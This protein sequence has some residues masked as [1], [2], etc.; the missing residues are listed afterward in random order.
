MQIHELNTFNG[1][2]DNAYFVVDNGND[3]GKITRD[4]ILSDV[5]EDISLL[6]TRID[7]LISGLTIDS[8]VIDARVGANGEVYGSLGT[9]IRTQVSDITSELGATIGLQ[10]TDY[11][12]FTPDGD[13]H[14]YATKRQFYSVIAPAGS[15]INAVKIPIKGIGGGAILNA[16]LWEL[17]PDGDT[18]TRVNVVNHT[19]VANSLNEIPV[20]YLVRKP[21]YVALY[22]YNCQLFNV[23]AAGKSFLYDSVN[24]ADAASLSLSNLSTTPSQLFTGGFDYSVL[25]TIF[26]KPYRLPVKWRQGIVNSSGHIY[27]SP[28]GCIND[29]IIPTTFC[30]YIEPLD[31]SYNV[32]IIYFNESHGK[33]VFATRTTDLNAVTRINKS[34]PYFTVHIFKSW[35]D[36]IPVALCD[37][38]VALYA[39]I[40][41]IPD[42]L[43]EKL[44]NNKPVLNKTNIWSICH[45]GYDDDDLG[46]NKRGGYA[47]AALRGFTHGEVDI[48]LTSDHEVVCCHDD[49]FVDATSGVTITIASKTLAEL[50]TC[51]YYGTTIAT[52]GE[53]IEECK[54]YGLGLLIDQI[55]TENVNF[56]CDVVSKY[57][58]WDICVMVSN[59][60][61]EYPDLAPSLVEYIR[62]NYCD[63]AMVSI[64]CNDFASYTG[65]LNY[66]MSIDN[67]I[68]AI[69]QYADNKL[70]TIQ[71]IAAAL[72][73]KCRFVIWTVDELNPALLNALPY[74]NGF[75]S[76]AWSGNDIFNPTINN[77]VR[78]Y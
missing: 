70:S 48:K 38:I 21:C 31:T 12:V 4:A 59:Y 73:G 61:N 28:Y 7:N 51:D 1:D 58:A 63:S 60:H 50:Q 17:E 57:N 76:N 22:F 53:I 52:L 11:T 5:E 67:A 44:Y 39:N 35:N 45:Q 43:F 75:T 47:I 14:Y 34:Y 26:D 32:L 40:T 55:S 36:P 30:D 74:I 78:A 10:A 3:T 37:S 27:T 69:G 62:T 18:L 16:E 24:N 33:P 72:N 23:P 2:L 56:A 15:W 25:S 9:A 6:D 66:A 64:V 65:A 8:E 42:G 41:P 68:F 46:R 19:P 71:T 54:N 49:T 13:T 77:G 20:H 29:F